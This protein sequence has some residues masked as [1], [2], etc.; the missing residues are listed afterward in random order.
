MYR[1][2]YV[3][4]TIRH[5]FVMILY[6]F[7]I[8]MYTYTFNGHGFYENRFHQEYMSVKCIPRRTPLLHRYI[9]IFL[10]FAPERGLWVLVRT[11]STR[12]FLRVSAVC[13]L[14]ENGKNINIFSAQKFRFLI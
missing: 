2:S 9:P 7:E 14:G 6:F 1:L 8:I 4:L 12:R 3:T 13:V 11:A 5:T 10:I